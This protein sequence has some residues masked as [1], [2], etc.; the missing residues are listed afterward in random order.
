MRVTAL[1]ADAPEVI[2]GTD[3]P[4]TTA[5]GENDPIPNGSGQAQV[6]SEQ[7]FPP[8]HRSEGTEAKAKTIRGK[9][10]RDTGRSRAA[11]RVAKASREAT[12]TTKPTHPKNPKKKGGDKAKPT[13]TTTQEPKLVVATGVQETVMTAPTCSSTNS[14]SQEGVL[15]ELDEE[16]PSEDKEEADSPLGREGGG[17][18]APC[19]L[20]IP[21]LCQGPE[22]VRQLVEHQKVDV[23]L[24][25]VRK[26]A[27][28]QVEGFMINKNGVL[29]HT[30]VAYLGREFTR[31]VV[32]SPR[33]RDILDSAHNGVVGGHFSHNKMMSNLER[34]F[35]WPG[36][37]R[38]VKDFCAACP[39]CHK[40]GRI[41]PPK[42][43]PMVTTPI[44][45]VPYERIACDIVG[46]LYKT[47]DGNRHILILMCLA[48]R[49]PYCIPLK[50]VD[51]E[52]IAE[53][54]MEVIAHTG[55]PKELLTDQGG[56]FTCKVFTQACKLLNIRKLKTTAYHPQT[57][58]ILE[59]WHRWLKDALRCQRE[60]GREWD[61]LLKYCLLAYRATPHCSTGFSP[62]ELVNGHPLRGPLEAIRDGWLGGEL[63]WTSTAG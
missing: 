59:M 10:A 36:L 28:N 27:E 14:V 46:P 17:E 53:G 23:L 31:I 32:P 15:E 22:E 16:V 61:K 42:A 12:P 7:G 43:P 41:V 57:N 47:S 44:I 11:D 37:R 9:E 58:G 25:E 63:T 35:I 45:L 54:L 21:V 62:Y 4:I 26:K 34:Y 3:H 52:S 29:L 18:I 56:V 55:I 50:R 60:S 20:P 6:K 13:L 24:S 30:K 19:D 38:D 1:A 5:L 48:T 40:A 2:L 51:T 8:D 39:E 33:R 49:Y